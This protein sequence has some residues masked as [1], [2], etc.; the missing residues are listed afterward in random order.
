MQLPEPVIRA[1][2]PS[3]FEVFRDI[4]RAADMRRDL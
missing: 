3:D 1:A 2:V 4:D